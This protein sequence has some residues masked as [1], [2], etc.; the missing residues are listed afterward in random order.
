MGIAFAFATKRGRRVPRTWRD[1]IPPSA[2]SR[3]RKRRRVPRHGP[4]RRSPRSP[5]RSASRVAPRFGRGASLSSSFSRIY[6]AKSRCSSR[7]S[8][9]ARVLIC[10]TTC[11]RRGF[12]A[13]RDSRGC[14]PSNS[15]SV[16]NPRHDRT[17]SRFPPGSAR[18]CGTLDAGRHSRSFFSR[19]VKKA[20][21][22]QEAAAKLNPKK[23]LGNCERDVAGIFLSGVV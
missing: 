12:P 19:L 20:N 17:G 9:P 18:R 1:R 15:A 23:L 8:S 6:A 21:D 22:L 7:T 2:E 4:L 10:F 14:L 5:S 3:F 11:N 16:G 13:S